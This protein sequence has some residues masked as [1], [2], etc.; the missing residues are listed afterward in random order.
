[1]SSTWNKKIFHSSVLIHCRYGVP[2]HVEDDHS[3]AEYSENTDGNISVALQLPPPNPFIAHDLVQKVRDMQSQKTGGVGPVSLSTG[4]DEGM[5]D[6]ALAD[7]DILDTEKFTTNGEIPNFSFTAKRKLRS[8]PPIK[9]ALNAR[10]LDLTRDQLDGLWVSSDE[11]FLQPRSAL[12]AV[13][14]SSSCGMCII[15]KC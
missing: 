2:Y 7:S 1:M 10:T 3:A 5:D 8:T 6:A 11:A 9:L 13:V 14:R 15:V 4:T 12:Y